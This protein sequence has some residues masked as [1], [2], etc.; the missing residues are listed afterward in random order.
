MS[1]YTLVFYC[2]RIVNR[3][4]PRKLTSASVKEAEVFCFL[5]P[6][7]EQTSGDHRINREDI[8]MSS[9]NYFDSIADK[10]NVIREEYFD[11]KLKYISLSQFNKG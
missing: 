7:P 1:F 6:E 4:G 2:T 11:E 5:D 3:V 8:K 9:V 10:W